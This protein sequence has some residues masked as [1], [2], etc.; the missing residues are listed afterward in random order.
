MSPEIFE[1][2]HSEEDVELTK[3]VHRALAH[4]LAHSGTAHIAL[5]ED[6]SA[7]INDAQ[8]LTLPPKAL[9]LFAE[10]LGFLA[11]GQSIAIMSVENDVST[12]TAAMFLNVSRPYL[13]R[14]LDE[15]K[16]PYH[17]VG[18][19]RRIK[20]EDVLAYKEARRKISQDALQEL[21]DQAQASDL[22]R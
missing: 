15:G 14:L 22:E 7:G 3:A 17:K 21:A 18:S 20:F 16:L 8:R 10:M 6:G 5:L 12:H 19:H 11:Q 9:R 1:R 2:L 4:A 13:V